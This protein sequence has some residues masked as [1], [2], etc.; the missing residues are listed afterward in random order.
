MF[1]QVHKEMKVFKCYICDYTFSQIGNLN[2]HI[3]SVHEN[4]TP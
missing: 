4:K 1:Q 3:A 2:A